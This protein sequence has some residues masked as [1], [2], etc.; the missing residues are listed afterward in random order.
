MGDG[1]QNPGVLILVAGPSGSGKDTLI[2]GARRALAENSG[3]V[4]PLRFITRA[5]QTGEEHIYVSPREFERLQCEGFF[6]LHWTAHGL[7]YGISADIREDLQ[8]GRAAIFNI[9]R[10]MIG[11]ARAKWPRAQ[12]ISVTA[13]PEALRQRLNA[14]GRENEAEVEE[15]VRR[16][17]DKASAIGGPVHVLDNSGPLDN[18][19]EKFVALVMR[20]GSGVMDERMPAH[21]LEHA[22][23]MRLAE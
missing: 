3:F 21:G 10:R 6:F 13:G 16:A 5:D 1:A 11:V 20:L 19:I 15:R 7:S 23:A 22:A 8:A 17:H 9:S 14:R 12:V 2:A 4:F 18:A